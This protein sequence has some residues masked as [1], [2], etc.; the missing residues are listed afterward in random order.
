MNAPVRGSSVLMCNKSTEEIRK[1]RAV[2]PNP[3]PRDLPTC[4]HTRLSTDLKLR[5]D[6]CLLPDCGQTGRNIEAYV[7]EFLLHCHLVSGDDVMLKD[8][9]WSG[10][11]LD[12]SLNLPDVDPGWTLAQYI[13]FVLRCCG[14]EFTVGEV[15]D[16]ESPKHFL[17]GGS[18]PWAPMAIE[19][20]QSGLPPCHTLMIASPVF[21]TTPMPQPEPT[22]KF[23]AMFQSE[24]A[25]KMAAMS[26][27]E[28]TPKTAAMFQSES[29]FKMAAMSQ[30]ESTPK[31][32]AMF[33][34]ES[35][36][37]MAAMLQP[38]CVPKIAIRAQPMSPPARAAYSPAT[39]SARVAASPVWSAMPEP[40]ASMKVT[41]RSSATTDDT[42]EFPVMDT[43]PEFTVVRS[44]EF[45]DYKAFSGRLRLV[46]SLADPPLRSVRAAGILKP[47]VEEFI[48]VV[49][50]SAV[51]PVMAVAMLCVWAVHCILTPEPSP[52]QVSVPE[53]SPVQEFVPKP[54]PVRESFPKP[55]QVQVFVPEPS[56]V[57]VSVPEPS[58]V[59]EFVP[60]PSPVQVSGPESSS[61]QGSVSEMSPVTESNL[62]SVPLWL[63]TQPDLFK[64][65]CAPPASFR[66]SL[67]SSA[68]IP[69]WPPPSALLAL[70]LASIWSLPSASMT[71]PWP[72]PSGQSAPPLVLLWSLPPAPLTPP[73]L[74]APPLGLF[75]S[76]PSTPLTQPWPPPSDQSIPPLALLWSLPSAL[77]IPSWPPPLVQSALPKALLWFLPS[78]LLINPGPLPLV[79]SIPS[80]ILIWSRP[81]ALWTHLWPSPSVPPLPPVPLHGPGPPSLP[82]ICLCT[83]THLDFDIEGCLES[84]LRGGAMSHPVV[85]TTVRQLEGVP[86]LVPDLLLS[87]LHREETRD[88][89]PKRSPRSRVEQLEH[90]L[91]NLSSRGSAAN[92][93]VVNGRPPKES[94][95]VVV[96]SGL[97]AVNN[98]FIPAELGVVSGICCEAE[99]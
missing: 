77:L 28:S 39:S 14:S 72:L 57:L 35:A 71:P 9:F 10:L 47:S 27:P 66:S 22:S 17:G 61:G 58:S 32:A 25:F 42:Q 62:D 12:I 51:L 31:T 91:E 86:T 87:R 68:L 56:P 82:R 5:L 34:S 11:D 53:P 70:P 89:K 97:P 90:T 26:Q 99:E 40:L 18:R 59:Q 73:W 30:P 1:I 24:S 65:P 64:P 80:L 6:S 69:P 95:L 60:K 88:G 81:S 44:V 63:P 41:P 92:I 94:L 13:D 20:G 4:C 37:K 98:T 15:D 48:E 96:T 33:Q 54:S 16:E 74:S 67:V 93:R 76:L 43:K 50:L 38:E 79:L 21:V 83:T 23:A 2:V 7:E 45:G 49:P 8:C 75:W 52:V 3:V 19:S 29:A 78:D 84:A 36:L 55:S 85:C 46:S